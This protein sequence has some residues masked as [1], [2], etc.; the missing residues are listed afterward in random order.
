LGNSQV[1]N[2]RYITKE[3]LNYEYEKTLDHGGCV[4]RICRLIRVRA[5]G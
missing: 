3:K 5:D 1:N 4:Y 2:L